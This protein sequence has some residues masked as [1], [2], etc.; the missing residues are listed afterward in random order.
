MKFYEDHVTYLINEKIIISGVH[1]DDLN[2]ACEER[3]IDV[4]NPESEGY[5]LEEARYLDSAVIMQYLNNLGSWDELPGTDE[6]FNEMCIR[7]DID[8]DQYEDYDSLFDALAYRQTI[9]H[10]SLD[11]GHTFLDVYNLTAEEK[12]DIDRL[13]D[14][15]VGVMNHDTREQV[16][17]ELAPCNNIE[18]LQRYLELVDED[19]VIG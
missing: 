13:W 19:L 15:I 7:M 6:L 17:A 12:N 9:S 14:A 10:I 4:E 1:T 3:G 5:A 2:E 16:H 18:F 8:A 11:N